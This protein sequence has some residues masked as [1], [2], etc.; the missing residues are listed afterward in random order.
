MASSLSDRLLGGGGNEEI[1]SDYTILHVAVY[2]LWLIILVD[3]IREI[4]DRVAVGKPFFKT[5][6]ESVYR[7]LTTLGLV[8]FFL[9]MLGTYTS[10]NFPTFGKVHLALTVAA[11]METLQSVILG[12]FVMRNSNMMWVQTEYQDLHHYVEIREEFD[13][14]EEKLAKMKIEDRKLTDSHEKGE[15]LNRGESSVSEAERLWPSNA[16][17]HCSLQLKRL[18]RFMVRSVRYPN[19][20]R[21]HNKLLMQLRFHEL[22]FHFIKSNK[23]P[24]TLEVS[25][26]LKRSELKILQHLVHIPTF[27]WLILTAILDL[28]YFLMGVVIYSVDGDQ[29]NENVM[30]I[31]SIIFLMTN[32][33]YVVISS[34]IWKKMGWI[35]MKI[36]RQKPEENSDFDQMSLFWF[37][38]PKYIA[39]MIQFMQFGFSVNWG[40]ILIFG[41]SAIGSLYYLVLVLCVAICNIFYIFIMCHVLPRF[42][43]CSS[44]GQ[45]VNQRLVQEALARYKL[46]SARREYERMKYEQKLENMLESLEVE[47]PKIT[48]D[49]ADREM[50]PPRRRYRR[51]R[52]KSDGV[53]AMR[54][55][56]DK[57]A[58]ISTPKT[59]DT[60]V[61]TPVSTNV[62]GTQPDVTRESKSATNSEQKINRRRR[63]KALSDVGSIVMMHGVSLLEELVTTNTKEL[64][65]KL[66]EEE[67]QKLSERE[68]E[69]KIKGQRRRRTKTLSD[70]VLSMLESTSAEAKASTEASLDSEDR[71]RNNLQHHSTNT[72]NNRLPRRLRYKSVSASASIQMMREMSEKENDT[73]VESLSMNVETKKVSQRRKV[74]DSAKDASSKTLTT[75]KE[76]IRLSSTSPIASE[77]ERICE[78]GQLSVKL[79]SAPLSLSKVDI[80]QG[81]K[82]KPR[83]ARSMKEDKDQNQMTGNKTDQN[84]AQF[85]Q[86]ENYGINGAKNESESL[87]DGDCSDFEDLPAIS[88]LEETH[89]RKEKAQKVLLTH[90][91]RGYCLGRRCVLLSL[92]FTML[93]FLLVSKRIEFYLFDIGLIERDSEPV[94][95]EHVIFWLL[96][97]FL[98]LFIVG[99]MSILFLFRPSKMESYED[100]RVFTSAIIDFFICST[101]L[102][103]L[104]ASQLVDL[105][106]G[107]DASRLLGNEE[108]KCCGKFGHILSNPEIEM[109]VSILAFRV[110]RFWAAGV[111]VSKL[112]EITGRDGARDEKGDAQPTVN[113]PFDPLYEMHGPE[114]ESHL[115][116][117]TGSIVELWEAAIG[118]YPYIVEKHGVFSGE[119]LQA[120]LG[121]PILNDADNKTS[122]SQS[123]ME[124]ELKIE[125]SSETLVA[126]GGT[127]TVQIEDN[128]P[129]E[130][131]TSKSDSEAASCSRSKRNDRRTSNFE[132]CRRELLRG[133]TKFS[134]MSPETQSIILAGS[135]NTSR[136][137]KGVHR[138]S[139]SCGDLTALSLGE[140]PTQLN[141]SIGTVFSGNND[142]PELL[143]PNARLVRNMRRCDHKVLPFLDKWTVV[144]VVMTKYE[145]VYFDVNDINNTQENYQREQYTE[146][147][148]QALIATKGGKE[149]RLSDVLFGRRIIGQLSLDDI[150]AVNIERILPH[151]FDATNQ[152]TDQVTTPTPDEYWKEVKHDR[153]PNTVT[154]GETLNVEAVRSRCNRWSDVNEDRLKLKT[155]HD[156][157]YLRFYNDLDNAEQ[158][159]ERMK[160]EN[161]GKGPVVNN[162]SILWCQTI[163]RLVGA[164][165]LDQELPHFGDMNDDELRDY[166][167]ISEHE[168]SK[169]KDR[170]SLLSAMKPLNTMRQR[171]HRRNR[172]TDVAATRTPMG[173]RRSATFAHF[174]SESTEEQH[175]V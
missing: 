142:S 146:N 20:M 90:R 131:G 122:L 23:L 74:E 37:G 168:D 26:Y 173:I 11:L 97:G 2:T 48:K 93:C 106:C 134:K 78:D 75:L 109:G 108:I 32:V 124:N 47:S 117:E 5:V 144:D 160:A 70:G 72:S 55:M 65:N 119:L 102:G 120:M 85:I 132:I 12:V 101:C 8:E 127:P 162:N 91:V 172:S 123:G 167:I 56:N 135:A 39:V 92:V 81:E 29:N 33:L 104:T 53:L 16:E 113:L 13:R 79:I 161:D 174:G 14:V 114:E 170:M 128:P 64:R 96:F 9:L 83:Q 136:V 71:Q 54:S 94:P 60:A 115:A 73:A 19:L 118:I 27:A 24:I 164:T 154:E 51:T 147:V 44:L 61:T 42:T 95:S 137:T 143:V 165:K 63:R 17:N 107:Q 18:W 25:D 98:I 175:I 49:P 140:L 129:T 105:C 10:L 158:N 77:G 1:I 36:M 43:V 116:G 22:K 30:V 31:L 58:D 45:L 84:D 145:I 150:E 3:T 171:G 139:H 152:I 169:G 62:I 112:D 163:G 87:D 7:E 82:A 86:N 34:L 57:E 21:K 52:T 88:A 50:K 67:K 111:I 138:T 121:L 157:L 59:P 76:G 153:V 155:K 35:F 99:D 148:R 133:S 156:T 66:P 28:L 110:L 68:D 126:K 151:T 46:H 125:A 41:V 103:L 141:N 6:L 130:T 159:L 15:C 100:H 40:I 38:N 89:R 4:L 69:A 80:F 166:I 149:L